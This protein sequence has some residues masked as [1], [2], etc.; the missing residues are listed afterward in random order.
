MLMEEIKLS[1]VHELPFCTFSKQFPELMIYRWCN[2]SIDYLEIQEIPPDSS[3]VSSAFFSFVKTVGSEVLYSVQDGGSMSIMIKCMC[4]P[5]NST[6][7]MAEASG[8]MWKAPVTY[9]GGKE[10]MTVYSPDSE[11]FRRLYEKLRA[12]GEVRIE[13]KV[14]LHSSIIKDTFTISLSDLFGS[15]TERQLEHLIEAIVSGYF[16]VP[17][18]VSLE[19]LASKGGIAESTLQEH[20][21]RSELKL[22]NALYPYLLIYLKTMKRDGEVEG[23]H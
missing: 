2:S 4:G 20:L 5:S 17:R 10:S 15:M 18:R 14:T 19:K 21:S 12:V 11:N 6:L 23:K 13:K 7:R 22:M 9:N 1:A 16:D 3:S 8:C